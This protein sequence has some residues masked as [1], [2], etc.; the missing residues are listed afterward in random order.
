MSLLKRNI[1]ANFSGNIWQ[2]LMG[3]MFIPLYIKF[4]GV[5][6]YGLIGFYATLLTIFGLLDMGLSNTLNREMA[7]LSVLPDKEQEMRNLVRTLEVIFWSIAIFV[8]ITVVSL[9]PFISTSMG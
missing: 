3:L 6:S 1:I 8:G 5:E 7:R 4:M 2:I 9:S